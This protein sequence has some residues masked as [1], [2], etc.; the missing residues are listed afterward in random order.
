M[1]QR[2]LYGM[3][4]VNVSHVSHNE[5][6]LVGKILMKRENTELCVILNS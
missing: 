5:L 6:L 4:N 1:D 2:E 3:G